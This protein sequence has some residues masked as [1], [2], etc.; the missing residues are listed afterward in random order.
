MYGQKPPSHITYTPLDSPLDLVD[1]SLQ[2]RE[3]TIALLK[4]NLTLAQN[5]MKTQADKHRSERSFAVGDWVFVKLQPYRQNSLRATSY[6]KL[7]PKYFGP[8]KVLQKIGSVAYKLDLP[9]DSKIHATFHVSQLKKKRGTHTCFPHLPVTLTA[10]GHLIVT[11]ESVLGRR[12][13]KKNNRAQGQLLIKWLNAPAEDSTWE[14]Y[15]D[16][17]RRFPGFNP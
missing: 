1:C 2:H 3:A 15:E 9:A 4:H 17:T 5:R 8:F 16:I 14:D 13:I 10:H 7:S 6:H 11:P 12:V